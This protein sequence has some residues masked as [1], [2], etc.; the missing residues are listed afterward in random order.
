M[1]L[2]KEH[3]EKSAQPPLEALGML[4]A[5]FVR[6][7]R[8][9]QSDLAITIIEDLVDDLIAPPARGD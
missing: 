7:D 3:I 5:G 1:S 4:S 9:F 8:T 6:Q 2:L